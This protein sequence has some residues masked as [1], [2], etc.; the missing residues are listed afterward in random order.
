MN[1]LRYATWTLL[2]VAAVLFCIADID[3]RL[4]EFAAVHLIHVRGLQFA[5]GLPGL[6][7]GVAL[8]VP[9]ADLASPLALSKAW[10]ALKP[11]SHA[12]IW[13]VVVV[14]LVLKPLFGRSGPHSWLDNR[15]FVFHWFRGHTPQ[16]QSMPSGEAAIL[17]ATF[18]VLWVAWPRWRWVY[19]L[20]SCLEAVGLVWQN[21]HFASDVIAG[22]AIG[23]VG[24][25]LAVARAQL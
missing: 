19:I 10:R 13:T 11:C 23:A 21:W 2:V 7:L 18:G 20:I 1:R 9:I 17:A 24:A 6:L 25:T 5:I 15:E 14:E 3:R 8:V 22:A 12:I 16:W 4:A